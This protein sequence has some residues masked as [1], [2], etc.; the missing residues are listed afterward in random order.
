M[1]KYFIFLN[2]ILLLVGN[3]LFS[4]IHHLQEHHSHSG[5]HVEQECQECVIG[6]NQK[7]LVVTHQILPVVSKNFSILEVTNYSPKTWYIESKQLPRAP[8]LLN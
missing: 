6:D 3:G 8:P 2:I 1:K 5:L 7:N 4:S